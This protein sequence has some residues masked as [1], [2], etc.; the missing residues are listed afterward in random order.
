MAVEKTVAKKRERRPIEK[1]ISDKVKAKFEGKVKDALVQEAV[2]KIMGEIEK[3]SAAKAEAKKAAKAEKKKVV[4]RKRGRKPSVRI[5]KK[6][7]KEQLE[8]YLNKL[9]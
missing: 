7:S 8:A 5:L 4:G 9:D 2:E 1:I 3:L 6:F